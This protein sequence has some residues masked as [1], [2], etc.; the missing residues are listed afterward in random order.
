MKIDLCLQCIIIADNFDVMIM[1]SGKATLDSP[2]YNSLRGYCKDILKN[3]AKDRFPSP[4]IYCI[5]EGES[6]ARRLT[7]RLVP[8]HGDSDEDQLRNFPELNNLS[9]ADTQNL[10]SKFRYYD[11]KTDASFLHWYS[12]V[13]NLKSTQEAKSLCK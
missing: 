10:Q 1:W 6:M 12:K 9:S 13:S 11:P 8:S 5:E 2:I 4:T 7:S 3:S